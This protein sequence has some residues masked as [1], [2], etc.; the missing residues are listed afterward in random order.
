MYIYYSVSALVFVDTFFR[1]S[2]ISVFPVPSRVTPRHVVLGSIYICSIFSYRLFKMP[3]H[4]VSR[5]TGSFSLLYFSSFLIIFQLSS[6]SRTFS[7]SWQGFFSSSFLLIVSR[8]HATPRC[9]GKYICIFYIFLQTFQN[10]VSQRVTCHV[11]PCLKEMEKLLI[12][13]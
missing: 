2:L 10:T 1:Y 7:L 4:S 8:C 6:F 11:Q 5:V 12:F 3:C 13:C 9:F